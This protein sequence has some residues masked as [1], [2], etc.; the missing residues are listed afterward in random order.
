[1]D[2]EEAE[3]IAPARFSSLASRASKLPF[4]GVIASCLAAR[5]TRVPYPSQT[6]ARV[7]VP[8]VLGFFL[9][10]PSSLSRAKL[11]RVLSNF[12][13]WIRTNCSIDWR[14]RRLIVA[15]NVKRDSL[16]TIIFCENAVVTVFASVR[17][18]NF[19]LLENVC[20]CYSHY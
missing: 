2:D 20:I 10:S 11:H 3:G 1:M 16:L 7:S 4:L 18:A 13:S 12:F 9:F 6:H 17:D 19:T 5:V 14:A 8:S 15:S